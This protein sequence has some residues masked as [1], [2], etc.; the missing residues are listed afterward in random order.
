MIIRDKNKTEIGYTFVSINI[1]FIKLVD[2]LNLVLYKKLIYRRLGY[3]GCY[4]GRINKDKLGED[5]SIECFNYK[6][7]YKSPERN[8]LERLSLG[9]EHRFTGVEEEASFNTTVLS[10]VVY[11]VVYIPP[12]EL[13]ASTR[14]YTNKIGSD[15]FSNPF[16]ISSSLIVANSTYKITYTKSSSL[17]STKEII[18]YPFPTEISYLIKSSRLTGSYRTKSSRLIE[19]FR[20]IEPP[21]QSIESSEI[22]EI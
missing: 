10:S 12:S 21:Y 2:K 5:I 19:S 16:P 22:I 6:L 3:I 13:P 20:P 14:T 9:E 18:S 1:P 17:K 11:I 8:K 4:K 7:Y 15:T